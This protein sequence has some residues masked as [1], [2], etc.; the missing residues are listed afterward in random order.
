[1]LLPL[2][3]ARQSSWLWIVLYQ[4]SEYT[5]LPMES[6]LTHYL[7]CMMRSVVLQSKPSVL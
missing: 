7:S 5:M 3:I 2:L 1:M 4:T 6:R